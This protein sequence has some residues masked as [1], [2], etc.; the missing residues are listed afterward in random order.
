MAVGVVATA[1][2]ATL[3]W[4]L[5]PVRVT[6]DSMTPTL[7][8]GDQVLLLKQPWAGAVG[9]GDVVVLDGSRWSETAAAAAADGVVGLSPDRVDAA[10]RTVRG[11]SLVKR[12]VGIGGDTVELDDG[13]LVVNGTRVDEPFVDLESVDGVW[14][15]PVTV[16]RDAVFVLGDARATSVDS[17]DLGAAGLDAVEGRVLGR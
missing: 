7:T 8:P 14:F 3:T 9:R 4:V 5:Q 15:G 1:L 6:S 12:V 13:A 16:P 10:V 2:A 17:R 11:T